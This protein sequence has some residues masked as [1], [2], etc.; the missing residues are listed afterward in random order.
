MLPTL[1]STRV[2]CRLGWM[3][4]MASRRIQASY[5]RLSLLLQMRQLSS[6]RTNVDIA[7]SLLDAH[8]GI[9]EG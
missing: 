1:V 6:D 5:L 8:I 7:A 2:S 4:I 9:D 3:N